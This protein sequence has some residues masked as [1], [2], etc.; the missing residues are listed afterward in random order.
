SA[1]TFSTKE[2]AHRI[3]P[4][5]V[6]TT[7]RSRAVL[8][9]LAALF[10]ALGLSC[11]TPPTIGVAGPSARATAPASTGASGARSEERYIAWLGERSMLHEA[12]L[13]ARR[14]SGDGSLWQ[15]SYANPQPRAA[16]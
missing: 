11:Q 15:H 3:L 12:E 10:G 2:E 9:C 4:I 8:L 13:T 5:T 16:S 7:A 1:T 14:Y 6:A